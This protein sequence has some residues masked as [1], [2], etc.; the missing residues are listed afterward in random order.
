MALKKIVD[1]GVLGEVFLWRLDHNQDVAPPSGHWIRSREAVGGGAIM[2]CLIHQI[3]ALRWYGGEVKSVACMTHARPE[4]ME[5]E[6]AGTVLAHMKS[7]ALAELSINWWTKSG[8]GENALWYER[9]QVC[10]TRGEAYYL[11]NR[12]TFIRLHDPSD[13]TAIARYGEAALKG[14]VKV[15]SG[16]WP[17]HPRCIEEWVKNLR[18]EPSLVTTGGRECRGTVEVAE[19]AYLAE[20]SGRVVELPIEPRRWG[21]AEA[22]SAATRAAGAK[23][24]TV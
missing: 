18:G 7:G 13:R 20:G 5:G 4:R 8:S 21:E 12:G 10:G 15:E 3:D 22:C 6:F 11:N 9:V 16:N 19:A 17:G 23:R 24:E 1:S 14:F 2:S